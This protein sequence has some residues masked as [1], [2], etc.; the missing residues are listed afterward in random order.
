M[1]SNL[2]LVSVNRGKRE[3]I[4]IG[5]KVDETGIFKYP[6]AESVVVTYQGLSGDVIVNKKYHGGPDQ[7]IY[8]YSVEDYQWWSEKL[9]RNLLPGTFGENLTLSDFGTPALRIGDRFQI[10]DVLLEVSSVRIPCATFAARM[11]DPRFVKKFRQARRPGAYARVLHP[12]KI[13][14]G[15][16]VTFI[17]TTEDYPTIVEIFE[18]W[19]AKQRDASLVRKTLQAPIAERLRAALQR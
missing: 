2:T 19:Y 15:D 9:Q 17:P 11:N 16:K 6:V 12:G 4:H 7:A 1:G 18:L 5:K 14:A 3:K 13:R 10:N 8:L